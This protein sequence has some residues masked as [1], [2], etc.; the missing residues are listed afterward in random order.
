MVVPRA[1]RAT[2][3]TRIRLATSQ[4]LVALA[5]VNAGSCWTH[6]AAVIV[7]RAAWPSRRGD[8]DGPAGGAT[9]K[10]PEPE[11]RA[12]FDVGSQRDPRFRLNRAG[13]TL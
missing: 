11:A 1:G 5:R 8:G 4:Q 3:S 13:D 12:V 7:T 10:S 6:A 9:L 2:V